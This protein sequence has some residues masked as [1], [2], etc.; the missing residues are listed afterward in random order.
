LNSSVLSSFILSSYSFRSSSSSSFIVSVGFGEEVILDSSFSSIVSVGFG[1]EIIEGSSF[2]V[3]EVKI[4]DSVSV[5]IG[6]LEDISIVLITVSI[7]WELM[8]S[9]LLLISF[10]FFFLA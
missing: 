7:D 2:S 1:E 9:I 3:V 4:V 10:F 6:V 5:G 8:V